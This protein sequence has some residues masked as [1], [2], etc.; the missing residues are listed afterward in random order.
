LLAVRGWDL[1]DRQLDRQHFGGFVT[2][3]HTASE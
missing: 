3:H 2:P 1:P